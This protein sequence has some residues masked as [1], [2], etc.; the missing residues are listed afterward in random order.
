[1]NHIDTWIF[2]L[3]NTL[4]PAS[5][6]L[7]DQMHVRMNEF[8]VQELKVSAKEANRLRR[9]Y[10]LKYGTSLRGLMVERKM[11]PTPFLD[12]V[13]DIDY[14]AVVENEALADALDRLDGRKLIFTNG[15]TKHAVRVLE[16]LGLKNH[17]EAIYDIVDSDYIP[18]PVRTPYDK[19]VKLY[20]IRPET[21]TFFEDIQ[22][23]LSV[24][25]E[26]GMTTVLISEKDVTDL[27][28]HIDHVAK[29]V[30]KFLDSIYSPP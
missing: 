29:D 6:K 18:K 28:A 9:D 2:D 16:K 5:C 11:P 22:Q 14:G 7:F 23:N 15:T 25:R 20:G 8:I 26:M 1:V 27:P 21:S 4:Y 13:H 12:Y 24:P 30:T 10:Y 3:D 17:F 19:F